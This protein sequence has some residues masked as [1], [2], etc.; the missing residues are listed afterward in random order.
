MAE[1][2]IDAA[3]ALDP[4]R[5]IVV[6]SPAARAAFGGVEVVVQEKPLGTADAVASARKALGDFGGDLLV[7]AADTPLVRTETLKPML[8]EHR[9]AEAAVTVLSFESPDGLP[10]GRVVR[11]PGGE[12]QAVVEEADATADEQA[13]S[14][15]NASVYVFAPHLLWSALEQLDTRNAKRELQ[16][17]SAVRDIV[18]AGGRGAVYRSPD[19]VELRGVNT[20]ADLAFVSEVLRQRLPLHD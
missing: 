5:L 20:P 1:W 12:L 14:E 17:T 3:R 9:R 4:E 15:L 19:A 10:Y 8:A 11:G 13:I 7:L 2:V 16:L 6:T 18:A